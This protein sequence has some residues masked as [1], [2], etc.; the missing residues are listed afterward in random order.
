MIA[1]P[2]LIYLCGLA[3][4]FGL[5][6]LLPSPS[7]PAE[8]RWPL[9]GA[10]LLA[11]GI[12]G[13]SFFR[14]LRGA[15]TPV[16]PYEPSKTLVT[17]GPYRWTRNPGYLGMSLLYS[18]IALTSGTLWAFAVLAPVLVIVDRGVIAREE[19]YLETRFGETYRTYKRRTRRWL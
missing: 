16:S 11:G 3:A 7:L 8:V 19:R 10:L 4:G 18:G 17:T 2:P 6:A 5:E 15:G 9:G 14:A 13:R 12:L 1:P